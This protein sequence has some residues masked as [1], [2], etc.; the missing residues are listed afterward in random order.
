MARRPALPTWIPHGYVRLLVARPG[1]APGRTAL[2]GKQ[3]RLAGLMDIAFVGLALI[4][5]A[6]DRRA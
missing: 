3:E 4:G 6:A 2:V 1:G 5:W